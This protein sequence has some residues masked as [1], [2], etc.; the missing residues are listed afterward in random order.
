MPNFPWKLRFL[1]FMRKLAKVDGLRV[2]IANIAA[3][4]VELSKNAAIANHKFNKKVEVKYI[5][6]FAYGG[7]KLR[8]YRNSD[9]PNQKIILYFHGG[10]MMFFD[11]EG[12]DYNCR[13]M[14]V[15]ND[16]VV[17][18]ANYRLSPEN[19]FPAAHDDAEAALLWVHANLQLL[20]GEGTK[21]VTMGD[22]AGANLAASLAAF[23]RDNKK[24]PP[25]GGQ[26]LFYPW[27][28]TNWDN[29]QS[30]KDYGDKNYILTRDDLDFFA[31]AYLA[32]PE[33]Y[34]NPRANLMRQK[35]L[36]GLP[37]TLI[38]TAQCDPLCSEGEKY[39]A[40]LAGAGVEIKHITYPNAVHGF[41]SFLEAQFK[42]A[43]PL[44]EIK[45]FMD[46]V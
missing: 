38:M 9:A 21:I 46:G 32:K 41:F 1:L 14:C 4:R 3:T 10:G 36:Q 6:D 45:A 11:L 40:M 34:I 44:W 13:R 33:D 27:L 39:A 35:T 15:M 26:V 17:V 37:K 43:E 19:K 5:E 16:C 42:K 30:A 24:I 8:V 29:H 28:D 7:Q 12:Q 31:E 23:A 22:S 18:N 20:K 2:D 25:L